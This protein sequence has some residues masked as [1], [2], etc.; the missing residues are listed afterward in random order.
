MTEWLN[1]EITQ[2]QAVVQAGVV[3]LGIVVVIAT[4]ARSKAIVPT[5]GALLFAGV[6]IWAVN[7]TSW[8]EEKIGQEFEGLGRS[9]Q[10][11]DAVPA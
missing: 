6:V 7:N 5:L 11:I 8:F 9:V 4:Y 1:H 10:I 2:V 3:L